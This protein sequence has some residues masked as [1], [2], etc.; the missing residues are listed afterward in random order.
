MFLEEE[1]LI[2][3]K[4]RTSIQLFKIKWYIAYSWW[5]YTRHQN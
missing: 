4:D 5:N 1:L 3:F 2:S